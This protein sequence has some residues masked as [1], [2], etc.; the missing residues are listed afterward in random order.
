MSYRDTE[1]CN[2]AAVYNYKSDT[3]SFMDL[4]NIVGGAEANISLVDDLYKDVLSGYSEYNTNYVSF[5]DSNIKLAIMLGATD[6][7]NNLTESRIY[8]IDLPTSGLVNL[9]VERETLTE[10]FVER[11]GVD[12]D[13]AGGSIR[14]YKIITSITPQASFDSTSSFFRWQVGSADL[15]N[16]GVTYYSDQ[17]FYPDQDYKLDMKVAGRYLGYRISTTDI[18]NFRISGFDAEIKEISRR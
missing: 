3:W 13:E 16:A 2:R 17:N 5:D 1:F 11:S 14:N 12:L 9:P 8:A 7:L 4:P 10:S 18:E 6:T 15:P